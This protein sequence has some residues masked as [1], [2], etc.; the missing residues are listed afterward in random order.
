VEKLSPTENFQFMPLSEDTPFRNTGDLPRLFAYGVPYVAQTFPDGGI[1][2]YTRFGWPW[3]EHLNPE[4]WYARKQYVARGTRLTRGTG[5]VYRVAVPDDRGRAI[6]IVVKFS[7]FAQDVPLHI[8]VTYPDAV[9]YDLIDNS[10]FNSPFFEFGQIKRIRERSANGAP[11]IMTGR[12]LAIYSP[13][14]RYRLWQ[15]GRTQHRFNHYSYMLARDQSSQPEDRR[16]TYDIQR[17]YITLFSWEKGEDAE[18]A[19]IAGKLTDTELFEMTQQVQ[20]LLESKGF[21][22]LDNKPR[23][24]IVRER[25]RDGKLMRRNGQYCFSLVDFELLVPRSRSISS[26]RP[27]P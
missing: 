13:P 11:R 9:P 21:L 19:F 27:S 1:M 16:L 25:K 7:R 14:T 17:Q 18:L 8:T 10:R 22:V 24:F 20:Q 5:A 26:L 23:H 2:W 12:P 15:L 6:D 3:R 4:R